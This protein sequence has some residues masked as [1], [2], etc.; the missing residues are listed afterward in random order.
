[1]RPCGTQN[2]DDRSMADESVAST[3]NSPQVKSSASRVVG[4]ANGVELC[5]SGKLRVVGGLPSIVSRF[6]GF[7]IGLPYASPRIFWL[8][9]HVHPVGSVCEGWQAPSKPR[10]FALSE[11]YKPQRPGL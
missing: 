6:F 10:H 3:H 9:S 11:F 1:M 7:S 4:R 2:H 5:P 8:R